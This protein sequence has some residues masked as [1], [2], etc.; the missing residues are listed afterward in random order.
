VSFVITGVI[1]DQEFYTTMTGI[2]S[3]SLEHPALRVGTPSEGQVA[4]DSKKPE[5]PY[6]FKRTRGT[7]A[8]SAIVD[9]AIVDVG[10]TYHSIVIRA[11]PILIGRG[12]EISF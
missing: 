7:L 3:Q 5:S 10:A 4:L 12:V 2:L 1:Y 6:A 8:S 9:A 11:S